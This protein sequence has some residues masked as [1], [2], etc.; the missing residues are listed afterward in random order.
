MRHPLIKLAIFVF[1]LAHTVES[2]ITEPVSETV[3]STLRQEHP[4]LM[5]TSGDLARLKSGKRNDSILAEYIEGVLVRAKKDLTLPA[6]EHVL[7][8]PRLLHV[9]RECKRRI[10]S[11]GLAWR[12]TRDDRYARVCEE[13]L[14][15]VCTFPDWNPSHF[16]DTAE[17]SHAVGV[18]YDWLFKWLS[19]RS[20]RVIRQG[21]I[22]HGLKHGLAA[23]GR[24]DQMNNWYW[25]VENNHNW[26]QVCNAG[27]AI[28]ALAV[29]ETDPEYAEVI[30]PGVVESLP[31]ALATYAPDGAW[32]EGPGYWH[33][34][35]SYTAYGICAMQTA[36]GTDFG[37]SKMEGLS[38]SGFFPLFTTGPTGL[39]VNF[40]DS[41]E[42]SRRRTMPTLFWLAKHFLNPFFSDAEHAVVE[43]SSALPEHI[44][45]YV[46]PSG[47]VYSHELDRLFRGPVAVAVFRSSWE[48]PSAL[49]VGFKAGYNQVAHGHLDLGS[50]ELDALGVRWA[51]DLGS[52]DYNLPDYWGSNRDATRWTYYRLNSQS[53]NLVTLNG[54]NQDALAES[55]FVAFESRSDGAFGIVDFSSAYVPLSKTSKRG[56]KLVGKRRAVLVQDEFDIAVGT[57]VAWGMTTD[58]EITVDGT[59]AVLR[60]DGQELVARILVPSQA[61]FS[62]ESAE[63]A[64]PQKKNE[65]VKRLMI[66]T[67]GKEGVFRIAVLL[68]PRWREG[69]ML[70][71]AEVKPLAEWK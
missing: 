53:H 14:L 40:A 42:F 44:I 32:P 48:D 41:G 3:L 16:L 6:L 63:Q 62:L 64:P 22:K 67:V 7:I 52:D 18:G 71:S 55:E 68:S 17:M 39:F 37:L 58:A 47:E 13:N 8:G 38:V 23:Y 28:G 60:Q 61:R 46:T 21:L 51:R 27:L 9:S 65:G 4:R 34:A 11:L 20:R 29:A 30:I 43:K 57:E 66:R 69:R 19:E 31:R 45:W 15:T 24:K 12:L 36:L 2:D 25:W 56:I 70:R 50:F 26:N 1:L 35:S 49:F 33:Y 59:T 54:K 10:Y 5:I